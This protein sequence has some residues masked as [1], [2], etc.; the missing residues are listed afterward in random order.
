[1]DDGAQPLL[2]DIPPQNAM[3]RVVLPIKG[4]KIGILRV[5]RGI[6]WRVLGEIAAWTAVAVMLVLLFA[7]AAVFLVAGGWAIATCMTSAT[8]LYRLFVSS[9]AADLFETLRALDIAGRVA[10]ASGGYFALL[11]ALIVLEAGLLGRRWRRFFLFPGIMLTIPS[12]LIFYF[13]LRMTLDAV[14]AGYPLSLVTE[15][16]LA[17]YL[18]LDTVLLA[19]F[20]VDLRPKPTRRHN[21]YR[22][23]RHE[24]AAPPEYDAWQSPS[25]SASLPL[26]HFG[27]LST[28]LVPDL[29]EAETAIVPVVPVVTPRREER[30]ALDADVPAPPIEAAAAAAG[31]VEQPS[32]PG[33]EVDEPA[34]TSKEERT[35]AIEEDEIAPALA[36]PAPE[37]A[38]PD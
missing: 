10:V 15:A 18:L 37:A 34:P 23:E 32:S 1:M 16:G 13:G 3:L 26:V 38:P 20:L 30:T 6:V 33:D 7:P 5:V 21:G 12:A 35:L 31:V 11:S 27:R 9:S 28:P 4:A 22:Y 29:D 24:R 14:T 25:P 36:R 19:G 8:T 2:D 17:L